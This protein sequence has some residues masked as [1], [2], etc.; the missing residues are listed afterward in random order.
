MARAYRAVDDLA[1]ASFGLH[2]LS[3]RVPY[4][5]EIDAVGDDPY[6]PLV[7]IAP[8]GSAHHLRRFAGLYVS[9]Y[10]GAELLNETTFK[11]MVEYSPAT[12]RTIGLWRRSV[13]FANQSSKFAYSLPET[14]AGGAIITPSKR[15]ASF[16]YEAVSEGTNTE[17]YTGGRNT[18]VR[19]TGFL[20][21]AD[22][23]TEGGLTALIYEILVPQLNAKKIR[24]LSSL[25]WHTNAIAFIGYPVWTLAFSNFQVDD[26]VL[27]LPGAGVGRIAQWYSNVLIELMYKPISEIDPYGWRA[28]ELQDFYRNDEGRTA[29]VY[30]DD[31]GALDPVR[32]SF[33]KKYEIDFAS[34]FGIVSN[35]LPQV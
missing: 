32:Q 18:R 4:I 13:R 24:A 26:E 10:G 28:E 3:A 34:L 25:K 8:M 1:D 15:V 17:Y 6:T 11:I 12:D 19:R 20:I 5:S 21:D 31:E 30:R 33:I 29:P 9:D 22:L 23:Q 35:L 14:D 2:G 16:D 27:V 7:A